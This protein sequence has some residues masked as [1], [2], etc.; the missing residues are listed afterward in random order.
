MGEW[1]PVPLDKTEKH[2]GASKVTMARFVR[3]ARS[4]VHE[5]PLHRRQELVDEAEVEAARPGPLDR[6]GEGARSV[7]FLV[8]R[9]GRYVPARDNE[10][11]RSERRRNWG[12]LGLRYRAELIPRGVDPPR[13]HCAPRRASP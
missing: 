5:N 4:A 6:L 7:P 11:A 13:Q 8:R 2:L 1:E 12:R 9:G 3:E 10:L